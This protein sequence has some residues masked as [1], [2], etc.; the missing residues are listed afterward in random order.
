MSPIVW[1]FEP[2]CLTMYSVMEKKYI[3]F[4]LIF[5]EY[6]YVSNSFLYLTTIS[7]YN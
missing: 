1:I 6:K 7:Q 4:S 2:N 3:I 5:C